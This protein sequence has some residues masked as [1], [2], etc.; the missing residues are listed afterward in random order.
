MHKGEITRESV[1]KAVAEHDELGRE[2]FLETYR[3]GKAHAYVLVYEG[4]E[5]DSKAIAGV[6]HKWTQGRALTADEFSGGKAQAVSWL[7]HL[8]FQVKKLA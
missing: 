8:G 5:Y 6:A 4:R 2:T 1:L 7:E 3:F